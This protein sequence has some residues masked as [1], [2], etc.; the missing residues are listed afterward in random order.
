MLVYRKSPGRKI[1]LA[2]T[3][4][5]L[6]L[7][8]I[9]CLLPF[10]H[11]L[12]ISLSSADKANAGLVGLWPEEFTL[13]AYEYVLG[14]VKFPRAFGY[15]LIRV[16]LGTVIG[17]TVTVLTAYPL[18]KSAKQLKGRG[19]FV[20]YFFITAFFSGGLVPTYMVLNELELL[21][22][23]WSLVLPNAAIFF[24]IILMVN[25]FRSIPKGMEEAAIVDG[26]SQFTILFR[27]YLPVSKA[28]LATL[29]LFIIVFHWNS[30]FDG[31]IYMNSPDKYPLQSYLST[32]ILPINVNMLHGA[33]GSS[34]AG[35]LRVLSEKSIK[36]A[37]VFL[38]ALPIMLVYP[39]LQKYFI[40]GLMLG[41]LKE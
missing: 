28:G 30:W 2:C 32:L 39:F 18:S 9:V 31:L 20:A 35:L 12:A 6:I 10:L 11:L 7:L 16:A 38:G 33:D 25:F 36:A 41:S 14:T 29:L 27:I 23:V 15:S 4:T 21:D 3:Y 24:N 13:K 8:T 22:T 17:M 5:G 40:K 34:A 1:F 37:N 19:F 26:A